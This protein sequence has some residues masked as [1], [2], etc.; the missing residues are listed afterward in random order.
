MA[1]T[2]QSYTTVVMIG[3]MVAAIMSTPVGN[4][5]STMDH[6]LTTQWAIS[7]MLFMP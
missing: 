3:I 4:Y 2:G 6:G 1:E 5:K 7:I